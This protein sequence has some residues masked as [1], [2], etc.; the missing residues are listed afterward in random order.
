MTSDHTKNQEFLVIKTPNNNHDFRLV[1]SE[2]MIVIGCLDH[3][4]LLILSVV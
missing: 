2:V 1:W 3:E 4:K